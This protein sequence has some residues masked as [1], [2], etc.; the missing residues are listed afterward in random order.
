M[1][2]VILHDIETVPLLISYRKIY[3]LLQ[4]HLYQIGIIV[5]DEDGLCC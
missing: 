4:I 3:H 1:S 5:S 2:I